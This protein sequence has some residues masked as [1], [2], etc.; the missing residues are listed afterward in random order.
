MTC[1]FSVFT[2]AGVHVA[3]AQRK[4]WSAL[5]RI[6]AARKLPASRQKLTFDGS[7][8]HIKCITKHGDFAPM[9]NRTVRLQVGLLLKDKNGRGYR[10]QNGQTKNP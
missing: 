2:R 7:I 4:I 9:V 1:N 10:R 3:S 8:E 6:G 5:W